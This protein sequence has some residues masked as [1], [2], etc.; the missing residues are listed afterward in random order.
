MTLKKD[1]FE[2]LKCGEQVPFSD[3]EYSKIPIAVEETKKITVKLNSAS[4]S[5]EIRELL[6]QITGKFIDESTTVFTPFYTNYGKNIKIGKN[7]FI[8]HACSFLDLGGITIDDNVMIA[9]RVNLT[10]E[11]HPVQI[12]NRQT[13]TT[14]H[15]HIKQ[16]AWIGTNV[17]ILP[18]VTIG[19]NS[20]VAAG[21]V[22]S[23]DVPENCIVGGTPAK[24][25]KTID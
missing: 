19:E 20:I 4:S 18:G 22:V 21:S 16:N 9:P 15:I 1:I 6:G 3:P 12:E 13:L 7:V 10:S 24:V 11:S 14:G 17:T 25:I 8:N 23:K 2:R 5:N